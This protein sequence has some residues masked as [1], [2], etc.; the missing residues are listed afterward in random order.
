MKVEDQQQ[1]GGEA[2]GKLGDLFLCPPQVASQ[3]CVLEN[4]F[5]SIGRNYLTWAS[6]LK[7]SS[8]FP[9]E[10]ALSGEQLSLFHLPVGCCWTT[11]PTKA[12]IGRARGA[13]SGSR[14]VEDAAITAC[15]RYRCNTWS[16]AI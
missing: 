3:T 15:H 10:A 13:G 6:D 2:K 12:F 14:C 8:E 4:P 11:G 7:Q 1:C 16:T 9:P 5:F